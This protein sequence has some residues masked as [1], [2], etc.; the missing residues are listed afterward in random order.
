MEMKTLVV[1]QARMGSTRLPGKVL[2]PLAGKPA[3]EHV[4]ERARAAREVDQVVIATSTLPADAA[5]AQCCA[6]RGWSCV[7]GSEDDVLARFLIALEK[8]PADIVVRI[9]GDCPLT[10]PAMIDE[11]VCALKNDP[12]GLDYISNTQAPRKIPH[13]LDVEAMRADALQRACNEAAV[14]EEREHV[15]PYFYRNP[16]LFRLARV[17]P[18]VDLSAHRWTLDTPDDHELLERILLALPPGAF[19]WRDTLEV[20][21]RHPEWVSINS[22]VTQKTFDTE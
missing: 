21:E 9:T 7:R 1:I 12:R 10:D 4:V 20:L 11:L 19:A 17:D 3:L 2:M 15:T 5:V 6:A 8:H 16:N 13:G 18:P 22:S 14:R